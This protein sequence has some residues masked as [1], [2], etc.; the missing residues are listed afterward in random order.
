[1]HKNLSCL[2]E[3]LG[4]TFSNKAYLEEALRHSSYANE[5]HTSSNERLEFLGDSVLG[6]IVSEYLFTRKPAISEGE[7]T[8]VRAAS[9]SEKALSSHALK[10]GIGEYLCLG[11]GEAASGGSSRP[12]L[13][14]D[15]MEAIIAAL[16]LDR[17]RETAR[18]F[19]L[20]FLTETIEEAIEGGA[21]RDYKTALQE[22]L[23]G[24]NRAPISYKVIS[25]TGPDHNKE[26]TVSVFWGEECLGTG[27]GKTK[28][29]AE[30]SAAQKAL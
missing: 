7:M 19:I 1:M 25:E 6:Q 27:S 15:A 4:Y 24:K 2:E 29:E 12:S 23:Q 22:K 3:L 28:K 5:H 26:F 20:S 18:A 17:G 8:R 11:R 14:A 10:M 13:L 30:Q 16:Y 9:V 21:V